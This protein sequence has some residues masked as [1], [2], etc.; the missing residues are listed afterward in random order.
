MVLL[1]C[2]DIESLEPSSTWEGGYSTTHSTWALVAIETEGLNFF[3]TLL[4]KYKWH[5]QA[6]IL[7]S[8]FYLVSI[9]LNLTLKIAIQFS[10]WKTLRSEQLEYKNLLFNCKFMKSNCTWF[11]GFLHSFI[12]FL[13][14][15]ELYNFKL[16]VFN[17]KTSFC[18]SKIIEIGGRLAVRGWAEK[19]MGS[20][21]S[22]GRKFQLHK[23]NS[24]IFS[25][26]L[27]NK[28]MFKINKEDRPLRCS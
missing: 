22:K 18:W 24:E 2:E 10:N 14:F 1:S 4:L 6:K 25:T 15:F 20:C 16:S 7:S 17:S 27:V 5:T 28:T 13:M 12:F 23:I 3:Q 11:L 26:T 9:I 21:Y 8:K 19:E